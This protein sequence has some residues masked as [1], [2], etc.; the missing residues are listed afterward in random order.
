MPF[1]INRKMAL[2]FLA[3]AA[4]HLAAA[5]LPSK[6][7]SV[8][9]ALTYQDGKWLQESLNKELSR[10]DPNQEDAKVLQAIHDRIATLPCVESVETGQ[11]VVQTLPPTV[12]VKVVF[13]QDTARI[14]KRLDLLWTD[15]EITVRNIQ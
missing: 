12:I 14:V 2:L 10:I 5:C 4:M 3:F 7:R 15:K 1:W 9:N 13:I 8:C 6:A 11:D